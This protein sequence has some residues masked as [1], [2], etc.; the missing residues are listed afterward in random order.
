MQF[1][2]Y[3]DFKWVNPE[4]VQHIDWSTF[5]SSNAKTSY[6]LEVSLLYP[7]DLEEKHQWYLLLIF[8]YTILYIYS[9]VGIQ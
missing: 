1:L 6:V 8:Q 3:K 2:P 9:V 7:E 5:D 4:E